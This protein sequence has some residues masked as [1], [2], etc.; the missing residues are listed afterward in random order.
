MLQVIKMKK[1]Q[2]L[3]DA[4]KIFCGLSVYLSTGWASRKFLVAV[5]NSAVARASLFYFHKFYA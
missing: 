2:S 3:A 1:G 5:K 4:Q